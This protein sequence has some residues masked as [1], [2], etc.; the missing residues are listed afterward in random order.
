MPPIIDDNKC[1]KCGI[2][3]DI[4]PVDVYYGSKS[5][6][7]PIV[8]YGDDCYFCAACIIECPTDAI[9]LRYPLYAQPSCLADK[10]NMKV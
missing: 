3:A 6:E 5:K 4:C 2:C 8:S 9:T 10:I 7:V 1:N